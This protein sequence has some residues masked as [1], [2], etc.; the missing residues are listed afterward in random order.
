MLWK[1]SDERTL[2][3]TF[4]ETI[5]EKITL[6]VTGEL[7]IDPAVDYKLLAARLAK[8]HNFGLIRCTPDQMGAIEAR[9]GLS[10]GE[11]EDS[12]QKKAPDEPSGDGIGNVNMLAL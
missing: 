10:E 2:R 12:T 4:L 8:V 1:V 11:L 7:T 6:F 9:Q 3:A 5:E